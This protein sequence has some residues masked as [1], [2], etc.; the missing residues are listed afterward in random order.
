MSRLQGQRSMS[1]RSPCCRFWAHVHLV[2]S[3]EPRV[4]RRLGVGARSLMSASL[5]GIFGIVAAAFLIPGTG[6]ASGI[7]SPSEN[8]ITEAPFDFSAPEAHE[9]D[10]T[11][12]QI[13]EILTLLREGERDQAK[14]A[15]ARILL[16]NPHEPRALE[17]SGMILVEDDKLAAAE[18]AFRR[19]VAAMP[20]RVSAI[21]RLGVTLL[22][23]DKNQAGE[24]ELRK[25][26]SLQPDHPIALR[27]L[28]SLAQSR[29]NVQ[30]AIELLERFLTT[31][32]GRADELTPAHLELTRLYNLTGQYTATKTSLE[33]LLGDEVQNEITNAAALTLITAYV[34]LGE[35]EDAEALAERVEGNLDYDDARLAFARAVIARV[36]GNFELATSLLEQ[37]LVEHPDLATEANYQLAITRRA[38][39]DW[40]GTVEALKAAAATAEP[41]V[42]PTILRDL[43]AALASNNEMGRAAELLEHY[44]ERRPEMP[45]IPYILAELHAAAGN[46]AA[47]MAILADLSEQHPEFGPTY[48]LQGLILWEQDRHSEAVEALRQAVRYD[49]TNIKAWLTL[50]AM[51]EAEHDEHGVEVSLRRGLAAN[52]EHP[53]LLYELGSMAQAHEETKEAAEL[54]RRALAQAPDHVRS[55]SNLALVLVQDGHVDEARQ[56]AQKAHELAP[57]DANVLDAYGW[58][59]FRSGDVEQALPILERASN[60]LPQDAIVRYH[61]GAAYFGAGQM[62]HARARLS[63]AL[64]LG[65]PRRQ[66]TAAQALLEQTNAMDAPEDQ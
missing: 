29:G 58:V 20:S 6:L 42:L 65:L 3:I 55:L 39:D 28:A 12:A 66:R 59:R 51:L 32:V 46:S 2:A 52:P 23:R 37:V 34:E 63:E 16:R 18:E 45:V 26:L 15:L 36:K 40:E 13:K 62:A 60:G 57:N 8:I 22:L 5:R 38:V 14:L 48:Y 11:L 35:F 31:D 56:L 7:Q 41:A 30:E 1:R 53:D 9:H 54:Y 43:G 4:K 21:A 17:L 27:Y 25:A 19:S 44:A 47:A 24:A 33:S 61:L 49:Q 10:E 50:A 64:E